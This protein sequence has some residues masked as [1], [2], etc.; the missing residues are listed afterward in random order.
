MGKFSTKSIKTQ[1]IFSF[2]I[3]TSTVFLV[4]G[5]TYPLILDM[6]SRELENNTSDRMQNAI[7]RFDDNLNNIQQQIFSLNNSKEFRSIFSSKG[8]SAYEKVSLWNQATQSF[9]NLDYVKNYC[10][11][12]QEDDDVITEN[13][14]YPLEKYFDR[15]CANPVYDADFWKKELYQSFFVKYYPQ[16][17]YTSSAFGESKNIKTVLPIGFKNS[18]DDRYMI[19]TFVDIQ[20]MCR[21]ID[22][23][24]LENLSVFCQGTPLISNQANPDMDYETYLDGDNLT[25]KTAN[26]SYSVICRSGFNDFIYVKSTPIREVRSGLYKI[27]FFSLGIVLATAL[28]SLGVIF[29]VTRTLVKPFQSVLEMLN[30]NHM[31]R[32]KNQGDLA[33][34]ESNIQNL[35]DSHRQI[36]QELE[37]KNE[38]LSGFLYHSRL[39]NIYINIQ[40][41]GGETGKGPE[42]SYY[43]LSFQVIYR[44]DAS[45]L[46]HKTHSE[47]SF[48]LKEHLEQV[49]KHHFSSLLLFQPE[50]NS[51]L[52]KVNLS[53]QELSIQEAMEKI[54]ERLE[55][56]DEYCYFHIVVSSCIQNETNI[57]D[58]YYSLLELQQQFSLKESTQ[59]LFKDSQKTNLNYTSLNSQQAGD[60][61]KLVLS[62]DSDGTV[63]LISNMLDQGLTD[64]TTLLNATLFCQNIANV[65]IQA[66]SEKFITLPPELPVQDLY[67]HLS[68]CLVKKAFCHEVLDFA[69]QSMGFMVQNSTV[70]DPVIAG[71]KNYVAEHYSQ[72][73]TME[74]MAEA[75]NISKSY[76]STY[77]KARTGGNL[78]NYIQQYRVQKAVEL[79][80]SSSF[81][82]S[83]IGNQV[84]IPNP[85]SFIRVF[86]KHTGL[87]PSDYR[88]NLNIHP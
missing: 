24:I 87:T 9:R 81:R 4:F 20:D 47:I 39:K 12:L 13:G 80:K 78:L 60:L 8:P 22:P 70:E 86:K 52:A 43:L 25:V 27:Y 45:A 29:L 42:H 83:D 15:Y 2:I 38:M 17:D 33:F 73:F 31:T 64:K 6:F 67:N 37:E 58:V 56:E 62:A 74:M 10:L 66:F 26:N 50:K 19:I 16:A 76:L 23:Y 30:A 34:I 72:E 61:K 57:T 35:F 82:L 54:L 51:I 41:Y 11:I 85:N 46:I 7:L 49:L 84:G 3:V 88:K 59:L 1:L 21:D 71:V 40:N 48:V 63:L 79:M 65:I 18:F 68:R 53:A 28:V 5:I 55:L 44:E 32:E 36:A 77:F 75:L 14:I 69:R